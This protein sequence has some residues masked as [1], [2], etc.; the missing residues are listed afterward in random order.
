MSRPVRAGGT[1]RDGKA[2]ALFNGKLTVE[3]AKQGLH[4]LKLFSRLGVVPEQ[5][6][7]VVQLCEEVDDP[8]FV[9][10]AVKLT[11]LASATGTS[12]DQAV[13]PFRGV[14]CHGVLLATQSYESP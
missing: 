1:V 10:A 8:E 14:C 3:E 6:A 13:E 5:H 2:V 4:I 11:Q 9:A 12:Y 7:I